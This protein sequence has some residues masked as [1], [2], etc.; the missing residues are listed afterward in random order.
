[1]R[2][3]VSCDLSGRKKM[4]TMVTQ[5]FASLNSTLG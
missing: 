5:G 4:C 2:L 1:M 3:N